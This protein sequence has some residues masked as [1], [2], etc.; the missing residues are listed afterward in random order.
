MRKNGGVPQPEVIVPVLGSIVCG[1]LDGGGVDDIG[2]DIGVPDA[3]C[4]GI[5]V[6]H[7]AQRLNSGL[8]SI[9]VQ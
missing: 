6:P 2:V 1:P 4:V 9:I 7:H 8:E 5:G 3:P